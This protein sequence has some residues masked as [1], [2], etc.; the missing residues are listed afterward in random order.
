MILRGT[1]P[2]ASAAAPGDPRRLLL[3]C[4]RAALAAVDARAAVRS[5]LLRSPPD[6]E[7]RVIGIG[8]AAGA[9]ALGAAQVLGSRIAGGLVV[10]PAGHVPPG[11]RGEAPTLAIVESAHPMPDERSLDAGE[12][13]L[14]CVASLP[15]DAQA[16]CLVS[17]GASSLVEVLRP[18]LTLDD[19]Q[20]VNRW[21]LGSG[22]PIDVVNA[23]RCRLSRIKGGGLARQLGTRH[24]RALFVSDVPGD[25]PA[26]IGSGLL[27]RHLPRAAATVP[28]VALPRE[29][30]AILARCGSPDES[31]TPPVEATVV[32]SVGHACRAAARHARAAGVTCVVAR[33]RFDGEAAALGAGFVSAPL[34]G[35]GARMRVAGG[36]S[37]V[38][39]PASPGRGGRNQHLALAAAYELERQPPRG[40]RWLLAGATDG[41]DGNT[42]DAGA[43]VDRRTCERGRDAGYDPHV[44]LERADSGTFL[45]G[46]G[47]LLHTGPTL[48]NVGDLVLVLRDDGEA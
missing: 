8:K 48:T 13:L 4:F 38:R 40:Q 5:A 45:E 28:G 37:T 22:A 21:A 16:L 18:D 29:V 1:R 15:R 7:W 9:M 33:D 25:D 3:D 41:V 17:G 12:Q 35:R 11:L 31:A 32:S 43:I 30:A 27:H 24:V 26:T 46:A 47:A 39:L 10:V 42:D 34:H 23:V 2:E 44:S 19:L 14:A 36:E 6:G 20:C